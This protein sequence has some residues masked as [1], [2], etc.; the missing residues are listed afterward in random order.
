MT[1]QTRKLYQYALHENLTMQPTVNDYADVDGSLVD[2]LYYKYL[3]FQLKNTDGAYDLNWK[4]L[5][6]NDG[7]TFITVQAEET[8]GEGVADSFIANPATYRYY[9][10]QVKST[11][12]GNHAEATVSYMAKC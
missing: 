8:L 3:V 5:A 2:L 9:K 7:S 1:E 11:V 6:S 10:M 12:G 4:V